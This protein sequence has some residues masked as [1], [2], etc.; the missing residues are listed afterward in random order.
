ME[1]EKT[2]EL[3]HELTT[4]AGVA[5]NERLISAC[6]KDYYQELAD[7][8]IY[9]N[10]GSIY[11]VKKG[12]D[13]NP[14]KVMVSGH[15]DELGL[16][17]TNFLENGL[18][19]AL[20]LGTVAENSL[21]GA[22][23]QL[24]TK[25]QQHYEG[26][27]LADKENGAVIDAMGKVLIDL[28]FLSQD[29]LKTSG[30]QLGDT[31]SFDTPFKVSQSGALFS[32]NWNGRYAPILGIELLQQLQA[33]TLPFDLYVGCTV[34]E[35]VG[36]RGIQTATN[37]VAPDLAI[38]LDTEQAFD[39]QSDVEDRRGELGQGVLLTY[40]DKTV[41]PNR[42]LLQTFKDVCVQEALKY[43]YYYSLTD[44]EAGWVNKLRTGC[45]TLLVDIPVR[46]MSTPQSVIAQTDYQAAKV[47]L[48]EFIKQLNN[49]QITAFKTENR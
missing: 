24:T 10:L 48:V 6:L 36:L 33:V 3:M 35:Q 11:A 30:I 21:L 4:I 47:G 25:T 43:Q 37:K 45:P 38:M 16:I 14:L 8:I 20:P 2:L 40:Y 28:G 1:S 34:Q 49:K 9:D 7:E 17:V 32:R 29:D 23:V 31:L 15:M 44:S 18:V 41:L 5:N 27:I 42:L 22:S 12:T 19:K 13:A 39:Y 26:T 46:N